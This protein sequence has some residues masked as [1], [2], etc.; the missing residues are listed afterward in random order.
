[1]AFL[2]TYGQR[3][4]L[5]RAGKGIDPASSPDA[6]RGPPRRPR[7]R[8]KRR[9]SRLQRRERSSSDGLRSVKKSVKLILWQHQLTANWVCVTFEPDM[10]NV[11]LCIENYYQ[12]MGALI[13]SSQCAKGIHNHTP[14]A[15]HT[16]QPFTLTHWPTCF[17]APVY[18]TPDTLIEIT[19]IH[20]LAVIS[21]VR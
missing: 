13:Q 16:V 1:M 10:G 3:I 2:Y 8:S 7:W 21:R 15:I 11:L 6:S 17:S 19:I 14:L 9:C 5:V 12:K 20:K 4:S 18:T